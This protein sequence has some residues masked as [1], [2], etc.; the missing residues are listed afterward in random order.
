MSATLSP[1]P[2]L[3][4]FDANGA[5][6]AGGKLYSYIAGTTTP[7]S[8]YTD[9][10]GAT[11]NAN[12]VILDSRGEAG[13]WLADDAFYKLSLYTADNVLVWTVDQIASN[14][15][16]AALAASG[17]S[18]LVGFIQ[19]GTGAVA[20]TVQ[21]KLRES[22]SV[23]DFGAVGDGVADDTA[24]IQAA[25][26]WLGTES[27]RTLLWTLANTRISSAL[28]LPNASEWTIHFQQVSRITQLT[29]NTPVFL[30]QPSASRYGFTFSGEPVWFQWAT[31]QTGSD[32]KSIGVAFKPTTALADGIYGWQMHTLYN[33]NGYD[34][35]AL[36]PDSVAAATVC[37]F[38][39]FQID[40]LYHQTQAIGR[41]FALNSGGAGGS[42][43]S[44]INAIYI[45][46]T[47][48]AAA[49][50]LYAKGHASLRIN[51]IEVNAA[52]GRTLYF[53]SCISPSIG[54]LRFEIA[55]LTG[56]EDLMSI[57]GSTTVMSI[58]NIEF[59]SIN[60]SAAAAAAYGVVAYGGAQLNI[61][62]GV[63]VQDCVASVAGRFYVFNPQTDGSKYG[64]VILPPAASIQKTDNYVQLHTYTEA[65]YVT[66]SAGLPIGPFVRSAVS[67]V[68]AFT[69]MIA[70]WDGTNNFFDISVP[71]D[72]YVTSIQ[73]TLSAAVT[74]GSI[75]FYVYK[76]GSGVPGYI[77]TI[78]SG[79]T[80]SSY[81]PL[82][83][84]PQ[85]I[86]AG[87]KVVRGDL[88]RV[89]IEPLTATGGGNAT[90]TLFIS[91]L[92]D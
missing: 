82:A 54:T 60:T 15:T 83:W 91:Q 9:S 56:G 8:T 69:P 6:L 55:T 77:A 79:T 71:A 65:P 80:G 74:A 27:R 64:R 67:G 20:T 51:V 90:A 22:V 48:V 39:G 41:V 29:N 26:N 33:E 35:L 87:H 4:F 14:T 5:P 40:K 59:Q 32:T 25:L 88:L 62:G 52:F 3:Q 50:A 1:V 31:N 84:A 16:L 53:E 63:T 36:H 61:T 92:A 73:V 34:L 76:N 10:T 89:V 24:A 23:K 86:N 30:M 49:N 85:S 7:Q 42:P 13:V 57:A 68:A 78:S 47:N 44:T 58:E 2:K 17:G 75:R 72:G 12:P 45:K 46:A 81:A 38:W 70:V 19:S 18:S 37:T 43:G 21:T 28:Q 11:A 66:S